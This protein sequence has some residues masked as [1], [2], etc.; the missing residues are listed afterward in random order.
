MPGAD[1]R[2]D[3]PCQARVGAILATLR[4]WLIADP[5]RGV[6]VGGVDARRR[7][8]QPDQRDI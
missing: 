7:I 3:L 2:D 5:F 8:A 1:V 6:V 4:M